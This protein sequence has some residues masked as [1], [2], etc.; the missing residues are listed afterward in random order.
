VPGAKR[1]GY[2]VVG[3]GAISQSAVLPAFAHSKKA[4]LVTLVTGDKEKGNR[5]AQQFSA[6]QVF[7]YDEF[8]ECLSNPEIEAIYVATP[9]GAHEAFAIAAAEAGKHVLC[10]KPLAAT[11]EQVRNMV[12]ACRKNQ[13]KLMTAYRKYFEP[14]SVRLKNMIASGKLGRIDLIHTLFTELRTF[15]DNSPSWLFSKELSGGGPLTDLGVYC[16]NTCRWLVNEDPIAASAI[17][18]ARDPRRYK[19]VEE[20][21]AFRLDFKSGLT[22]QGSTAYSAGFSSFVHVHGEKGWAELAPAFAFEE[23]RRISG[24]I[25]GGWFA[26]TF[27]PIDEFALE[28]DY[29]SKCIRENKE[30]EPDGEQ[31]LRDVIIIEAIY[32]AAREGRTVSIQYEH[33]QRVKSAIS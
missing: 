23:E 10:E 2:A 1:V 6:E 25:E 22:L 27:K 14:S 32:Q 29:F 16:L 26:K 13:V 5:L 9:Q 15:G 17:T 30:P 18:W 11:V 21:I 3:L 24:K 19:E 7:A 28:L 8:A 4:K 33:A 20:G 31:G 12:E